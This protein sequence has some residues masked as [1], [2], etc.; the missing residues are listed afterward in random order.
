MFSEVK[1]VS[2]SDI[3]AAHKRLQDIALRTPLLP[4]TKA[5]PQK[6]GDQ[7]EGNKDG[8]V[9]LKA[10]NLQPIGSFKIRPIGNIILSKPAA[11]LAA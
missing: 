2:I 6:E 10:E 7:K 1:T 11:S 9:Y 3:R 8:E 5:Q 4:L